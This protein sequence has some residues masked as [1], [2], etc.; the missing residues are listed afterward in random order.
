STAYSLTLPADTTLCNTLGFQLSVQHNVPGPFTIS[1]SPAGFLNNASIAAPT[2]MADTTATY[3]VVVT[4]ANGCSVTDSVTVTD[5]FDMLVSPVAL[6]TCQGN[7][8]LLDAG[9]PGSTYSW[10]TNQ[11]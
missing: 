5:A 9:F 1:W 4:D 10:N 6:Q 2:I 8:L 3:V 11:T 7:S